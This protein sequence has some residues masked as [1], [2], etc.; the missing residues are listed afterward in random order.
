M[1][2]LGGLLHGFSVALSPINLFFG[3]L[4]AVIGTIVGILP[5][6]GPLGTM[7]LLLSITYGMD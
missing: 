6:L 2:S 3:F 4:G 5:G 7:A 1:D